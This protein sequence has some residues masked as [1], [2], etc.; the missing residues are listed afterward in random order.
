MEAR[1]QQAQK[2]EAIGA[3][4]GGIAH[5]FNNILGP[6]LGYV[7]LMQEE[8]PEDSPQQDRLNQ[9]LNAAGRAKDLV[10]QIL[11]FSRQDELEVKPLKVQLLVKEALKLIRSSLPTTIK[12]RQTIDNECGLVMADPTQ[13]HQII[14]NLITNA[15]HAMQ[16]TGGTLEVGLDE[17]DLTSE[18]ITDPEIDPGPYAC[19]TVADSGIGM[20]KSTL[21]RI[22]DPYFTTKE[23]GKG[24][25]LGLAVVH[26]IV[27][28]CGGHITADSEP[29]KG[30]C[31]RVYLPRIE[32]KVE[33]RIPEARKAVPRG[34][35]RI[36]LVDDDEQIIRIMRQI[37]ESLGYHV[38]ARTS[39]LEAL[40]LFQNKS[41]E[42]DLVITDMT[43]PNMRGD[44]LARR[45]LAIRPDL[46]VIICTGFSEQIN[47]QKAKAM[48]IGGFVMKPMVK[49]EIAMAIRKVLDNDK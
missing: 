36:L 49:S 2:M 3:L 31:F 32:K 37:L 46:P 41:E 40:A 33:T 28:S 35:E 39:S 30:S 29:G 5:D 1:L 27:K 44:Q 48:G 21:E 24:T 4:A 18:E 43:M 11:T 14:M 23:K 26:G 38:T 16:E 20:E 8:L 25:G 15:Y 22:F 34:T 12:I 9:V 42:I 19:L 13:V 7:E 47:E 10:K 6:I 17:V 45:L